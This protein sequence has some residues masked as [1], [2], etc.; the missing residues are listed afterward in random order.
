MEDYAHFLRITRNGN[1]LLG[2]TIREAMYVPSIILLL[3][4]K[5]TGLLIRKINKLKTVRNNSGHVLILIPR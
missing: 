1:P 4:L 3:Y 5:N 2:K